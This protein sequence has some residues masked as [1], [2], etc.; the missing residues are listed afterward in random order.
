MNDEGTQ[1]KVMFVPL[2]AKGQSANDD[3]DDR[4]YQ[5]ATAI[6]NGFFLALIAKALYFLYSWYVKKESNQ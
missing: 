3:K 5:T 4:S 1:D 6:T 2:R